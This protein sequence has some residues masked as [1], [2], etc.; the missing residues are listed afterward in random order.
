MRDLSWGEGTRLD[1]LSV[2]YIMDVMWWVLITHC[3]Y[4]RM[5]KYMHAVLTEHSMQPDYSAYTCSIDG[6]V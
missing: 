3:G 1:H 2:W 4:T 5:I 6:Q